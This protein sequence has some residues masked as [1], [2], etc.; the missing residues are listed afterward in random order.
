MFFAQGKARLA[1]WGNRIRPI[2]E[3]SVVIFA[4]CVRIFEDAL[5]R[6]WPMD[7]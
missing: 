4:N 2:G 6:K 1:R 7:V 3:F 5:V